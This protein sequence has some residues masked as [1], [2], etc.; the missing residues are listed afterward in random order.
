M[1]LRMLQ[2]I[3]TSRVAAANRAL[4]EMALQD[5]T[6]AEGVFAQMALVG[7]LAGVCV[8]LGSGGG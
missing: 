2:V 3:G 1:L 6:P 8:A 5:V 4:L 7:S